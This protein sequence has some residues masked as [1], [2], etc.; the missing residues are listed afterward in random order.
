MSQENVEIV[1]RSYERG[2][3]ETWM[4]SRAYHPDVIM[5]GRMGWPE[6]GPFG[7]REDVMRAFESRF[8]RPGTATL[9]RMS[10]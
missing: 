7:G 10:A 9:S 6:P 3:R 2:T 5:R 1:R 4:L 8:E